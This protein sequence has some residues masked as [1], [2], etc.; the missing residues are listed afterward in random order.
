MA[1][2]KKKFKIIVIILLFAAYFILAARPVPRETI[3]VNKWVNSTESSPLEINL[4]EKNPEPLFPFTLGEHFGYIDRTGNFYVNQI[5]NEN[6]YLGDNLWT[7]Y[8]SKPDNIEIKNIDLQTI[9]NIEDPRGYPV[10]LDNRIFIIGSEQNALSE[11]DTSGK[12][13]WAYEFGAPITCIDAAAGLVLTGS[14][15]GVIEVLDYNGERVFYFEPGGSRYSV[16]LG[17]AISSDGSYIGIIS[18]IEEQRFLM[19]ERFGGNNDYKAVYHEFLG[20]GFRRAVFISFVDQDKR[21]VYESPEGLGSYDIKSRV[22][23]QIPLNGEIAAIENSGCNGVL[24]LINSLSEQQKEL[25]G[26]RFPQEKRIMRSE[27]QN[28]IFIRAPFKSENVFL[29]RNEQMIVVGG[30]KTLL[31]FELE[32]K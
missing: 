12:T 19:M 29:N 22:G 2:Q 6:I 30:G 31:A 8:G 13:L 25:V 10:L 24:F 15:D 7:E 21:L 27:A 20:E 18:G 3:L 23:V 28:A 5:K 16:I 26:I 1:Q 32:K 17:C 4:R 14:L 9:V 11:I